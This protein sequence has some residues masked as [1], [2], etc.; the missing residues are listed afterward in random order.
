MFSH[1]PM[2]HQYGLLGI[3]AL[4]LMFM[5]YFGASELRKP[6]PMTVREL[7]AAPTAETPSP[8]LP[9]TAVVVHVAGA[10]KKPTVIQA[11][12]GDRV[13]DAIRMAGGA[14]PEAD[15]ED[16][17]LAAKLEDGTQLYVP[18]RNEPLESPVAEVYAGGSRTTSRYSSR[19]KKTPRRS[20]RTA[21][22]P[23]GPVSLNTGSL[24][25]L[26]SLPGIGPATAQKIL[27]Y[28]H[29]HG[30][31]SSIDELLAVPGIGAKKLEKM[32][33]YLKL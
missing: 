8:S 29:D 10:V 19:P 21:T 13:Q 27:D 25:Q 24:A 15:L 12:S 1:L 22:N 4:A 16:I 5:A 2:R 11:K 3:A 28:R 26:D 14:S 18:K 32:R 6:A 23:S 30:G 9:K 20:S 7:P 17:N 33:K 31:F